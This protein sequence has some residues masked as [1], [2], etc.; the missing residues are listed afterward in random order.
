MTSAY[1]QDGLTQAVVVVPHNAEWHGA[2]QAEARALRSM[3]GEWVI[4]IHHIGSTAI[5]GIYA[6]PVIDLLLEVAEV[7]TLDEHAAAMES[8]GYEAMG[9]YGIP[10]RRY[11]RKDSEDGVRTHQVHAFQAGSSEV[12]RHLAFRDYLTA[13]P[14]VAAEYS[15]LKRKLAEDFPEDIHAYMEGKDPFIKEYEHRALEWQLGTAKAEQAAVLYR[16]MI[17]EYWDLL[18]GD[19]SKW[20]SRPYFLEIIRQSG[21]PA[22]DVACGTGRLLLDYAAEGV[23]IDGV[24]IS[25]EMIAKARLNAQSQGLNPGLYVQAMQNLELPRRYSTIIV[26]SSSFLHLTELGDARAALQCFLHHLVPGGRL[27]MSMRI[28]DPDP[29]EIAWEIDAEAIRP[30]DGK[31]IRRWFR[32]RYEPELRLQH[33]QD[34]YQ[35]LDGGLVIHEEVFELLALSDLVPATRCP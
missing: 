12:K 33:T 27:A 30:E 22:L 24:D 23:D 17:A 29:L 15:A 3:L 19:T 26:P 31:V 6:K 18:R 13:H 1:N 4:R 21:E 11:F 14:A 32:C 9:E 5:P 10:G 25:Q 7:E 34:R 28:M 20:S 2:F 35:V 8:L 16:G